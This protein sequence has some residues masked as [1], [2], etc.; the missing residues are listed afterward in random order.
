MPEGAYTNRIL[1]MPQVLN[2]PK[3]S[4]Y[5]RALNTRAL[6]SVLHMPDYA[7]TEF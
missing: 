4:E 5:G 1:N 2:M 7:L 6:H 3:S